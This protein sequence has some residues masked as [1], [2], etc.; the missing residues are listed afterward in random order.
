M[1]LSISLYFNTPIV[2]SNGTKYMFLSFSAIKKTHY[3]ILAFP[4]YVASIIV[5]ML[6]LLI[7][8]IYTAMVHSSY[9]AIIEYV[10]ALFMVYSSLFH[11]I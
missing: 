1:Q 9:A 8:S 3:S 5:A 4:M 11:T 7:F 6:L 2:W 10:K